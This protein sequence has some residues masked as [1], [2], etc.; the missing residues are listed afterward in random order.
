M[1]R[2]YRSLER[3]CRVQ[4]ALT[5]DPRTRSELQKMER[6]YKS[7]ADWLEKRALREQ[8]PAT[9]L[10]TPPAPALNSA[11]VSDQGGSNSRLANSVPVHRCRNTGSS[12][13][14]AAGTSV[15]RR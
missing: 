6:E 3:E 8:H 14:T 4:S 7:L 13:S 2:K 9:S 10:D 5:G 15:T 12:L 1:H 11:S